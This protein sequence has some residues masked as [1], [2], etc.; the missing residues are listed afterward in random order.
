[1]YKKVRS[2]LLLGVMLTFSTGARAQDAVSETWKLTHNMISSFANTAYFAAMNSN[3][4]NTNM[5]EWSFDGRVA[6]NVLWASVIYGFTN[7][8]ESAYLP[9]RQASLSPEEIEKIKWGINQ[10][11]SAVPMITLNTNFT[12]VAER[13]NESK[14]IAAE[15]TILGGALFLLRNIGFFY[16]V[17]PLL[18]PIN[19]GFFKIMPKANGVSNWA[20]HRMPSR[21]LAGLVFSAVSLT[22]QELLISIKHLANQFVPQPTTLS[23]ARF[24]D[25]TRCWFGWN[26]F[27]KSGPIGSHLFQWRQDFVKWAAEWIREPIAADPDYDGEL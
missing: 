26:L 17:P 14:K 7:Y 18:K 23:I 6:F 9:E 20:Y 2:A 11:G 22:Y 24:D 4:Q 12:M 13:Y 16:I 15:S 8:Y 3:N 21:L 1:M 19:H 27:G 25:C 5:S 10:V